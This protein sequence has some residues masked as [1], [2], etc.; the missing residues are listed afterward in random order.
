MN[1]IAIVVSRPIWSDTQ[2]KNGRA[3]P[4]ARLS[5]ISAVASTVLPPSSTV[6]SSPKS[7]AISDNCAVA[8]S[9]LADT[10]TN[11]TYSSQN[12]GFASISRGLNCRTDCATLRDGAAGTSPAAG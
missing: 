12:T 6:L 8:I 5:T 11:I 7:F 3:A 4:L 2:P 1:A 9:P 10:S